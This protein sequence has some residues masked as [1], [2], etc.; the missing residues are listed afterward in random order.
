MDV[1]QCPHLLATCTSTSSRKNLPVS[2]SHGSV[3]ARHTAPWRNTR[4]FGGHGASAMRRRSCHLRSTPSS[5]T[6]L[7]CCCCC[8]QSVPLAHE[9]QLHVLW[10]D[11]VKLLSTDLERNFNGWKSRKWCALCFSKIQN[12]S[13][14]E[15]EKESGR[16]GP[17]NFAWLF[18]IW[19]WM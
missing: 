4:S 7:V 19:L 15:E 1:F 10:L 13:K 8:F 12:L 2:R 9:V 5:L 14:Q 11:K 6:L 18:C 16:E 17:V 3:L